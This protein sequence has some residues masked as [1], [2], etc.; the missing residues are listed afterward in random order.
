MRQTRPILIVDEPQSVDGGRFGAGREALKKME[1][2]A[3][4][5]Y[6]ATHAQKFHQIYRL[7][8][9]DANERGLVKSIEVDGAKIEDATNNPYVKLVRV[10]PASWRPS[11]WQCPICS[12]SCRTAQTCLAR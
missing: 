5:R 9:F 8:A 4:L 2:L 11:G 1:P 7:D 6:S 3:T 10:S 12:A